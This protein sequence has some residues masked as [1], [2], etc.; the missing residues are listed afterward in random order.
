[1]AGKVASALPAVAQLI[2]A[3]SSSSF[4]TVWVAAFMI[5]GKKFSFKIVIYLML[6]K[7][8]VFY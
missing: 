6:K 7:V 1:M 5:Q 8:F 2:T 3:K 4:H